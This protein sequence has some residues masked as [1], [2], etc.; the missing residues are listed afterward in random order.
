[1]RFGET[2]REIRLKKEI[3]LRQFALDSDVDLAYLSRIER[4]TVAPPQKEELLDAICAG[5]ELGPDE[6]RELKDLATN[7][8]GRMPA[9]VAANLAANAG[10]PM[11]LRTVD[12]KRLSPDQIREVAEYIARNY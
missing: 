12:N 6:S 9:D 10:I 4:G 7:E 1:M 2:L 8:N 5:L 11:L 3:T